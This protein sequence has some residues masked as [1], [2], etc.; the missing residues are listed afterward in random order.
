MQ[1]D[2]T[3]MF[4]VQVLVHLEH[5]ADAVDIGVQRLMQWRQA[6]TDNDHDRSLHLGNG[7]YQIGIDIAVHH[8]RF[9]HAHSLPHSRPRNRSSPI[10]INNSAFTPV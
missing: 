7:A 5:I 2:R 9:A 6:M 8:H 1:R 4:L 10:P 3:D